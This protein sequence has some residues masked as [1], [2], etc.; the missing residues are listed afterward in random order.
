MHIIYNA[1]ILVK[2]EVGYV[3]ELNHLIDINEL[4]DLCFRPLYSELKAKLIFKWKKYSSFSKATQVFL[5]N[6][7]RSSR[8]GN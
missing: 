3:F 4:S 6:L 5:K 7:N 1:S 8:T 2:E